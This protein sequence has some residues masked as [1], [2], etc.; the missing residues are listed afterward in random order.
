MSFR[1]KQWCWIY[2]LTNIMFTQC[3]RLYR[4]CTEAVIPYLETSY[5]SCVYIVR[6]DI[7]KLYV[8]IL[9]VTYSYCRYMLSVV[10]GVHFGE[11]HIRINFCFWCMNIVSEKQENKPGFT[12]RIKKWNSR[13]LSGEARHLHDCSKTGES[14]RTSGT[15]RLYLYSVIFK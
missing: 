12:V 8:H 6:C 1:M 11:Q 5:L 10:S 13:L 9:R 4:P 15:W 2:I 7:L 14:G 3:L